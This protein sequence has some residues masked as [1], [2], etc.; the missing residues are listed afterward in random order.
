[1]GP[2]ICT[3]TLWVAVLVNNP[4]AA[5]ERFQCSIENQAAE[6]ILA[7]REQ[8]HAKDFVLAPLPPRQS[9]FNGK[10]AGLQAKLAVQMYSIIDD[11]YAH[12]GI[13]AGA[14][15][16]YRNISCS[17]RNGGLKAPASLLEVAV[18]VFQCQQKY[19]DGSSKKMTACV[20]QVFEYYTAHGR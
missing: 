2:I 20:E 10:R 8:G 1:M 7:L 17:K 18:P 3:I 12:P 5:R 13:K 19:G 14:Y 9:V 4:L 11:L 6:A 15:L 16:A